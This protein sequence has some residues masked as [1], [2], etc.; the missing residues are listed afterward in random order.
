MPDMRQNAWDIPVD[1]TDKIS[2]LIE[3]I[4][5]TV[6]LLNVNFNPEE[7]KYY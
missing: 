4:L 2:N 7:K 5:S 1:K 3:F 6:L